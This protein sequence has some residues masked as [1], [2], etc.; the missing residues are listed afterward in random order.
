MNDRHQI[1]VEYY[2]RYIGKENRVSE[3]I[4]LILKHVR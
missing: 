2:S 4:F 1:Y 3:Y